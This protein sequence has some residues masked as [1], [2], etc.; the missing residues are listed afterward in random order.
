MTVSIL[1]TFWLGATKIEDEK[2]PGTGLGF[3]NCIKL[4]GNNIIMLS[5][6][7]I[8]CHV[9]IDV[10]I[11]ATAPEI[12]KE[13]FGIS[14]EK[15]SF[16]SS[17]Y[18]L[19]RLTGC[20]AGAFALARWSGRKFFIVSVR[21]M[22]VAIAGLIFSHS[23][24]LVYTC[25]ALIGLGNSNIFPVIVSQALLRIP[26]RNNEVSGLMI[27]GLVGGTVFSLLMGKAT[28]LISTQ[29]G[30]LIILGIAVL[31]LF[32]LSSKLKK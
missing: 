29:A 2:E 21:L 18:F 7:G 16:A 6:L 26:D 27:M 14:R 1:A 28:D 8:M 19:F 25:I 10:G 15:A 32:F 12:M 9:G 20:L 24:E 3:L 31:Y 13:Y 11:N 4:L 22:A 30:G 23:K 5:F 17:V